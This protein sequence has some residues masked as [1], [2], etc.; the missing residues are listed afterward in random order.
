MIILTTKK[1]AEIL[2][3]QL[4]GDAAMTVENVSSDT[5]QYTP[6]GFHF[7]FKGEKFDGHNYLNNAVEQGCVAVV[8]DRHKVLITLPQIVVADTKL[9]LGKLAKWLKAHLH[10]KTVAIT[11]SSGKTTVKEMT[12]RFCK[13]VRAILMRFYLPTGILTMI[14]CH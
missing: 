11:G 3:G 7:C 12:A 2:N 1:L 5:R 13:K 4:V 6:N 14:L 10:P 8:V 9:A